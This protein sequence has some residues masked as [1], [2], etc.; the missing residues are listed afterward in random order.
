ME[1]RKS[2]GLD[3]RYEPPSLKKLLAISVNGIVW[4]M[5]FTAQ[6]RI[7]IYG[8]KVLG[9]DP[10]LVALYLAIFTIVDIINDPLI[11]RLSDKSTKLTRRL[12]KRFPFIIMGNI[13][14]V[15]FLILQ[16]IPWPLNPGG[17][18]AD[19]GLVIF[20]VIWIAL[21]IS[22]FDIFQ[23]FDEMNKQA[24]LTD[25]MRDQGTRKKMALIEVFSNN[26]FGMVLGLLIIPI[27]LSSFNAFDTLGQVAN[28]NA[29]FMMGIVVGL[30]YAISIPI[31]AFGYREPKEMKEFR[32]EFDKVVERPPFFKVI[33]RALS[34]RN[35]VAFMIVD[36]QWAV[37]N[38][39]FT[40]GLDFY[41]VDGLGLDIGV[42]I[43]PQ[44][45]VV[46]GLVIFGVVSYIMMKKVG[47]RKTTLIGLAITTLGFVLSVFSTNILTLSLFYFI[48]SAGIGMQVSA[49]SVVL[50]QALDASIL[51]HGTREEAQ[52]NS[53]N[54]MLR[55]TCTALQAFIFAVIS[56]IFGYDATL[57]TAN[58][59]LAKFGL[60]F[61]ISIF[62]GIISFIAFVAFWKLNNI[63][64]DKEEIIE[65]ELLKIGR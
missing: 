13:G 62:L 49:R 61:F 58:T 30:I 11:A 60:L 43:I 16:F 24:L 32:S 42:A 1:E 2:T 23:S 40:V 26:L 52:Y 64:R 34:D 4:I 51:K 39:S 53:L 38:K 55:S 6:A 41:V 9:L 20:A 25:L 65:Q 19:S 57:G 63:T 5:I 46:L 37:I 27:L 10:F 54:G 14:M 56:F 50:K 31:F 35:W 44:I 29:F 33:K 8:Q 48:G 15:I 18:L 7:Q 36:F 45:V 47:T 17:G 12:G 28:P 21:S 59:D 22:M 3:R